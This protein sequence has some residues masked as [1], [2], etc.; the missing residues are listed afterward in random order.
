MVAAF[1]DDL[2]TSN[3]GDIYTY[4]DQSMDAFIIEWS[5]MRTYTDND[6]ETFQAILYQ[7]KR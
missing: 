6:I 3:N 7:I 5:D 1:W 2:K 4:Y